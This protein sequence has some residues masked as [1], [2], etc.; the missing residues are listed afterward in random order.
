M[1]KTAIL[2]F[3]LM[4]ILSLSA[5]GQDEAVAPMFR[6][7]TGPERQQLLELYSGTPETE[8][9]VEQG[10]RWL[11]RQQQDGGSWSLKGPYDGVAS[12]ENRTAATSMALIA[13]LGAG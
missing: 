9:A 7:R 6:G 10:L 13:F 3:A 8:K 11:S 12:R 2:H 4:A 1:T 5:F